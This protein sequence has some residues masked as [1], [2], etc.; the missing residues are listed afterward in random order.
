MV[1]GWVCDPRKLDFLL[2]E[3][4][5][6]SEQFSGQ[7]AE[8]AWIKAPLWVLEHWKPTHRDLEPMAPTCLIA[9]CEVCIPSSQNPFTYPSAPSSEV[10]PWPPAPEAVQCN[11]WV[12]GYRVGHHEGLALHKGIG[13]R[14]TEIQPAFCSPSPASGHGVQYAQGKRR[15][16]LVHTQCHYSVT[17]SPRAFWASPFSL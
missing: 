13:A 17:M 1:T 16:F 10:F 15:F 5:R 14:G 9:N 3:D 4:W 7:L 6:Q 2:T 11:A 8:L 12:L